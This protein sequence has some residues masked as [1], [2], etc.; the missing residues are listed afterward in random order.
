MHHLAGEYGSLV[1]ILLAWTKGTFA[2]GGFMPS[3]HIAADHKLYPG[4]TA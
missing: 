3:L 2:V 1:Y 4:V